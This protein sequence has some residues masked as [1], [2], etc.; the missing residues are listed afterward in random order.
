[1]QPNTVYSYQRDENPNLHFD[2]KMDA[3]ALILH[4]LSARPEHKIRMLYE[5]EK[6]KFRHI[7]TFFSLF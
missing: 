6:L 2:R 7:P 1:M 4:Q 3:T 5:L